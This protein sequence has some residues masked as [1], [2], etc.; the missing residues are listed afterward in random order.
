VYDLIQQEQKYLLGTDTKS[1]PI[2]ENY[3]EK[4]NEPDTSY[5]GSWRVIRTDIVQQIIH[6]LAD[7][8]IDPMDW[9]CGL[10]E[11]QWHQNALA[12]WSAVVMALLMGLRTF[13]IP[14]ILVRHLDLPGSW[15]AISGKARGEDAAYRRI[16]ILSEISPL[17]S[18]LSQLAIQRQKA[19]IFGFYDQTGIWKP[20]T[21]NALEE[22]LENISHV[23][24]L[25]YAPAFYGL[26]HCF[27]SNML[28]QGVPEH[29][30]NY[31]M[32]HQS[33]GVEAFNPYLERSLSDLARVYRM[34]ARKM[35]QKYA[36][37]A[38]ENQNENF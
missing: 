28:E 18:Q 7:N 19:H 5:C 38:Q 34:A 3:T 27:R 17:L 26:R 11:Q 20:A 36:I 29:L 6:V 8:L 12:R 37:F 24:R 33:R 2:H 23:L 15:L 25:P 22:I 10:T 31:L 14:R 32:G 4:N 13:E 21:S 1:I 30:L 16:P 35:E 9:D